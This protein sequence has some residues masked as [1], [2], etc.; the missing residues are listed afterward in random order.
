MGRTEGVTYIDIAE[1]R[2]FFRERFAV[3]RLFL[4]AETGIL[5]KYHITFLHGLHCCGCSLAGYIVVRHKI[6]RPAK[7]LGQAF[8]NG[9]QRLSLIGAVFYFS[10]MRAENDLPAVLH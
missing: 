1:I 9:R 3:L 5:K 6:H 8:R 7:L 2:Q 4:A 10:K